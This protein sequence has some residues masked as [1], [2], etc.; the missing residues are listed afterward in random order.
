LATGYFFTL[1]ILPITK[2]ITD[3]LLIMQKLLNVYTNIMTTGKNELSLYLDKEKYARYTRIIT[4]IL[5]PVTLI[6]VT[7]FI[8]W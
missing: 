5:Y 8:F 2:N 7:H 4:Y 6:L 1:Q 3:V